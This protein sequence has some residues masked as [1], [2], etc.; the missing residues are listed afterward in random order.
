MGI[1]TKIIDYVLFFPM[2]FE[3]SLQGEDGEPFSVGGKEQGKMLP[4]FKVQ[5]CSSARFTEEQI[6]PNGA[7]SG[8]KTFSS[9]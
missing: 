7:I 1:S 5:K 6:I 9:M 3:S 2:I 4:A 8:S